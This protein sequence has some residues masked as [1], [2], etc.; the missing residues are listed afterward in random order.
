MPTSVVDV[1]SFRRLRVY[2]FDPSIALRL[3]TAPI[4]EITIRV[5]WDYDAMMGRLRGCTN[6]RVPR[7]GRRGSGKWSGLST[8]FP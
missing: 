8:L 1:P 2:A 4:Q 5:P 6:W 3:Q 7:S